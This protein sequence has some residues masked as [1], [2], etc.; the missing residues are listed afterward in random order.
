[1]GDLSRRART[2]ARLRIRSVYA[3]PTDGSLLVP[4]A[5]ALGSP[6][7]ALEHPSI[8][9]TLTVAMISSRHRRRCLSLLNVVR[10]LGPESPSVLYVPSRDTRVG[11]V[12]CPVL[13]TSSHTSLSPTT[14]TTGTAQSGW[15]GS[16]GHAVTKVGTI[17]TELRCAG[18]CNI[19]V[20]RERMS[21]R[22]SCGCACVRCS[23]A[24]FRTLDSPSSSWGVASPSSSCQLHAV[25]LKGVGRSCK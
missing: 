7:V 23:D 24:T 14:A 16:T 12:Q 11:A 4:A 18:Y 10:T 15:S 6:P 21:I 22:L 17:L 13:K 20:C 3:P 25:P 2:P 1:M 5:L 9:S 8:S 19:S